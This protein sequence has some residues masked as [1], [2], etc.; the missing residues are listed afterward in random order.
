M[1]ARIIE[2]KPVLLPLD[3]NGK[4]YFTNLSM[5]ACTEIAEKYKGNI[6]AALS[7]VEKIEVTADI[8]AALINN[9]I[10]IS[11]FENGTDE[12]LI[13]AEYIN[14][15]S[16]YPA[17]TG[18]LQQILPMIKQSF[19]TSNIKGTEVTGEDEDIDDSDIPEVEQKN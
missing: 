19:P 11:N 8:V 17:Y 14:L 18:Y 6:M 15:I 10:R 13:T 9:A 1:N 2:T 4:R 3:F 12:K 7:N 16:N 5:A